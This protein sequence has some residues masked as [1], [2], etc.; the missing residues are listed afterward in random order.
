MSARRGM[1]KIGKDVDALANALLAD[2]L[3]NNEAAKEEALDRAMLAAGLI[4]QIPPPR[5]S[6]K[7][8]RPRIEVQGE[9]VSDTIIRERR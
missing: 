1:E 8:E 5:D 4:T 3:Q 7:A 9:P 2:R 6:S